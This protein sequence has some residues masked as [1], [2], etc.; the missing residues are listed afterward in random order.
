MGEII[1]KGLLI[2]FLTSA[3]MGPIGVLC[4]QRTLNEGRMHGLFTG[5]GASLS[6]VLFA[7][8]AGLG[9]SFI[10]DFVEANQNPLFVLGSMVLMGLGYVVSRSNPSKK[11]KKQN[12][13]RESVW[14][15]FVSSFFLNL[16]NIG[17]LFLY[18]ALFA[19]FQFIASEYSF[20]AHLAGIFCIGIGAAI[21][22]LF[23]SYIVNKFRER[24][25]LRGLVL[26]N[27]ILGIALVIIGIVGFCKGFH[28]WMSSFI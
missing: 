27:R 1:L 17:I 19:Q 18:I 28:Q 21:W 24:F 26:F 7:I 13:R 2:G 25:N 5:L 15:D 16:S 20:Y 6:D 4:V 10:I 8:I 11:L 12:R 22:W 23:I 14:K 3:P 9:M